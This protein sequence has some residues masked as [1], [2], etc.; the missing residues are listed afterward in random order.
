MQTRRISQG[1]QNFRDSASLSMML[2]WLFLPLASGWWWEGRVEK[3]NLHEVEKRVMQEEEEVEDYLEE[4]RGNHALE[5]MDLGEYAYYYYDYPEDRQAGIT[6]PPTSSSSTQQSAPPR[7][8]PEPLGRPDRPPR[9][10]GSHGSRCLRCC[11]PPPAQTGRHH[12]RHHQL[13]L[14]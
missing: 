10:P 8:S 13:H 6:I 5:R 2:L 1:Y 4:Y 3:K 14:I 11:Q 7:W 12:H 9:R